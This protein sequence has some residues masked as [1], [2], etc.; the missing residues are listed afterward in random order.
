MRVLFRGGRREADPP[1]GVA[2]AVGDG[3]E[4]GISGS[5]LTERMVNVFG[6][7]FDAVP[8]WEFGSA[9]DRRIG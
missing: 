6:P 2:E 4:G 8:V 5:A 7:A 9:C 1:A 3:V